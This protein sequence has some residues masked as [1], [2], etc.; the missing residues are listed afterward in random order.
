M[1]LNH[2]L[3]IKFLYNQ[4]YT[5]HFQGRNLNC[6]CR[7]KFNL[8]FYCIANI[9]ALLQLGCN[10]LYKKHSLG[11]FNN[12]ICHL[13]NICL[14]DKVNIDLNVSYSILQIRSLIVLLIFHK[15]YLSYYWNNFLKLNRLK[16]ISIGLYF[17][18]I[19]VWRNLN[20]KQNYC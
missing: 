7:K 14:E 2:T 4:T 12:R 11:K 6:F 1:R 9:G 13:R 19:F 16:N 5:I 3:H 18:L 10:L 8:W 15:Y 17:C 20:M